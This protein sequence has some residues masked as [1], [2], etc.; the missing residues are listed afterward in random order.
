MYMAVNILKLRTDFSRLEKRRDTLLESRDFDNLKIC[1]DELDRLK[2]ELALHDPD[3]PFAHELR[4]KRA[5]NIFK[6]S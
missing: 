5:K 3:S 6:K 4:V 1:L 2:N